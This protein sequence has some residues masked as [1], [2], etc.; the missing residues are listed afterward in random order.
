M[1]KSVIFDIDNTL[2]DFGSAN[3]GGMQAVTDYCGQAFN[4]EGTRVREYYQKAWDIAERRI[5]SD[6]AAIHNRM[7]RFQCMVELMGQPLF[8]HVRNLYHKYWDTLMQIMQPSPGIVPFMEKLKSEHI[9]IGIGT[10]M[11]AYIQY[12]KLERLA[13]APYIDYI[14]TSEEAGAEKPGARFF[15]LCVE[16]AGCRAE[17]CAFIGDDIKKDVQGA[18]DNGLKGIWYSQGTVPAEEMPFPTI[19]SFE[20]GKHF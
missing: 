7:L 9:R 11:T 8:P 18:I 12:Q 15:A 17:E 10:D 5:G 19:V 20:N 13:L 16:K 14:V 3:I 1:I 2:Y 6:T 4:I